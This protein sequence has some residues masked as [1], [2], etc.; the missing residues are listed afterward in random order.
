[1]KRVLITGGSGFLGSHLIRYLTSKHPLVELI[2]VDTTISS[3]LRAEQAANPRIE[4]QQLNA[5]DG[6]VEDL[7]RGCDTLINL[8][9]SREENDLISLMRTN[10]QAACNLVD[11][12]S[13]RNVK[14]FVQVSTAGVYGSAGPHGRFTES[15]PLRPSAPYAASKAAADLMVISAAQSYGF[16]GIVVRC[17]NSFGSGQRYDAFVPTLIR[18]ALANRD[19]VLHGDGLNVRMWNEV[20]DVCEAMELIISYGQCGEIYNVGGGIELTDFE[21]ACHVV[22]LTGR[23]RGLLTFE[24]ND[25][26]HD[27]RHAMDGTKLQ[28]LGWKP[29]VD[30][31]TGLKRTIEWY[32]SETATRNQLTYKAVACQA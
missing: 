21:L 19:L 7:L 11:C 18:Q 20:Q 6:G 16:P 1:M 24:S 15:A 32:A 30:L 25:A 28:R 29:R 3:T 4:V 14:R 5:C 13:K 23:S 31:K 8:A 12:S 22:E 27:R 2:V 10:F 26:N 17:G 9:D